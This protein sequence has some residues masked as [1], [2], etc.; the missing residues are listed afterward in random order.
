MTAIADLADMDPRS[1]LLFTLLV[2]L[3][4]GAIGQSYQ[5]SL[6]SVW[7]NTALPDTN[8]IAAA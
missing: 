2:V 7:N 1:A 6:L 4:I 8:R 3:H 5:D